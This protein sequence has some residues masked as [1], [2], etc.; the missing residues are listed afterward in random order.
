MKKITFVFLFLLAASAI[1][2]QE[3]SFDYPKDLA[4]PPSSEYIK[5]ET[6][7]L[8]TIYYFESS[9]A[10]KEFYNAFKAEMEKK[11]FIVNANADMLVSDAGGMVN[12]EKDATKVV[13]LMGINDSNKKTSISIA[14]K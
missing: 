1:Y 6:T 11:K 13:L 9:L 2:S 14:Y 4:V 7:D 12:W 10:P 5:T 8:G 3:L